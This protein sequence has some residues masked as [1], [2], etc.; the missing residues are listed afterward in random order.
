MDEKMRELTIDELESVSA[1][2]KSTSVAS[3]SGSV[4]GN[5]VLIA[6]YE[7]IYGNN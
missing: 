6:M 4:A 1:G 2:I 5:A 3:Q 7:L